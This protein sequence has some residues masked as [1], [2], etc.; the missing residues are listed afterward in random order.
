VTQEAH[1]LESTIR[2]ALAAANESQADPS[3]SPSEAPTKVSILKD[4]LQSALKALD[5]RRPVDKVAL[6]GLSKWVADWI[7]DI[8]DPLLDRLADVEQQLADN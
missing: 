6:S 3:G 8:D 7:P 4:T 2:A 1:D 5:E